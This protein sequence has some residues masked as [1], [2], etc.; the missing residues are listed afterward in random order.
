MNT[1]RIISC[2]VLGCLFIFVPALSAIAFGQQSVGKDT[3]QQQDDSLPLIA[4]YTFLFRRLVGSPQIVQ[5]QAPLTNERNL[6]EVRYRELLQREVP[7]SEDQ[8]RALVETAGNC[9]RRVA[10]VDARAKALIE[11]LRERHPR[12]RPTAPSEQPPPPPPT[13]SRSPELAALQEEH[14]SIIMQAH[15]QMRAAFGEE[16]FQRFE[17]YILQQ[18]SGRRFVLPPPGRPALQM[19]A[20]VTAQSADKLISKKQF[21]VGEKIV[22]QIDLTNNSTRA[23]SVRQADL[24]D[25]FKVYRLEGNNR[26][27]LFV[28]PPEK[29]QAG[30]ADAAATP[31]VQVINVELVPGRQTVV[32]VLDLSNSVKALKPGSYGVTPSPSVLLNRP[33]DKSEFVEFTNTEDAVIF[34]VTP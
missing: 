10:D 6:P 9:Q 21:H 16:V 19:Q 8:L 28:H 13:S 11:A 17:K 26:A 31:T 2:L 1:R 18:G 24:Y 12:M 33:P 7:L 20:T 23:I 27:R 34:E 29:D 14:D 30:G 15:D 25:W 5:Q 3:A 32:G 4:R 22:I